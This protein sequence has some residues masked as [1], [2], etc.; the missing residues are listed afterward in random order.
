MGLRTADL[1]N[2]ILKLFS[3]KDFYGYEVHKVLTAEGVELEISRLYRVLNDMRK[4]GLLES[5]WKTS[6]LGPRKR[7]YWLGE[8]GRV[9]LNDIFVDAIKTVHNFYGIYL[10]SLIPK[11]NVFEEIYQLLTNEIKEN[12]TLVFVTE[13]FTPMHEMIVQHLHSKLPRGRI[14]LVKPNTLVVDVD[15][16]NLFFLDG[17]PDEISLKTDYADCMIVIDLPAKEYLEKA[18]KEWHRVLKPQ[19]KLAILTPS[20][21]LEQCEDPL[22]IGDFIEKHEHETIEKGEHLDK[23]HLEEVVKRYFRKLEAKTLVHMMVL[24]VSEPVRGK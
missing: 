4:E 19:G 1:K 24:C 8:K 5:S 14:V 10:L 7:M 12:A 9:A 2:V 16:N 13:G 20:I 3:H 6:R 11:I 15:L 21:L 22:T 17:F 23:E 18:L